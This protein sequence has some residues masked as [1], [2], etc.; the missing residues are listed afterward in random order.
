MNT[1][2]WNLSSSSI[3]CL[4]PKRSVGSQQAKINS[5]FSILHLLLLLLLRNTWRSRIYTCVLPM[6][7]CLTLPMYMCLTFMQAGGIVIVYQ[8]YG[9]I[10]PQQGL[11]PWKLYFCRHNC[12]SFTLSFSFLFFRK[13][14]KASIFG[15]IL[16]WLDLKLFFFSFLSLLTCLDFDFFPK[17]ENIVTVFVGSHHI[18]F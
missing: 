10:L 1:V 3:F 9:M 6:Y 15:S 18:I 12:L 7:M 11:F 13:E 16:T 17:R 2:G 5:S 4:M 14:N 8:V